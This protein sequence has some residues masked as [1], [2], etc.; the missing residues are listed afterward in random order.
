MKQEFRLQQNNKGFSLIELIV[1]I[2]ISSVVMLAVVGLLTTGLNLYK[3]VNAE[4]QLQIE[5]QAACGRIEELVQEA[6]YLKPYSVV[7]GAS[8]N[9]ALVLMTLEDSGSGWWY[10]IVLDEV[11]KQLLLSK[12]AVTYSGNGIP[13]VPDEEKVTSLVEGMLGASNKKKYLLAQYIT[14]FEFDNLS[15]INPNL[16]NIKLTLEMEKKQFFTNQIIDRRNK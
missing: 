13:V 1:T 14:K 3:N 5:A 9:E 8:I 11:G 2:L 10:Y 16:Y 4:T 12:T 7:V 6:Q 15:E